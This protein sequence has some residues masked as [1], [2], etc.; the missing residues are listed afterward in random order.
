MMV[1]LQ[2][3][4]VSTRYITLLAW[5]V[6]LVALAMVGQA[7]AI[8]V[9]ATKVV[10]LLADVKKSFDETKGKAMPLIAKIS[11]LTSTT[12]GIVSDLAPKIKVVSENVV[13][14]SHTVRQTAAKL[15]VTIRDAADK[16]AVTF[17]DVDSRTKVQVA[18][19]DGIVA[20]TL[21]ATAEFGTTVSEGI[22]VPARKIAAMVTQSKHFL[23]TLVDRAKALGINLPPN[24]KATQKVSNKGGKYGGPFVV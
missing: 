22:R 20:N 14:V 10:A 1:W 5:F 13:E 2:T 7:I 8:A 24:P 19:V 6:G 17:A 4:E 21:A 15:D 16:A 23:E 12:Q 18:R 9:L 3:A 11:D